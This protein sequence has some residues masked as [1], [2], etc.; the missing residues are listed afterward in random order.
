MPGSGVSPKVP[1]R[2]QR[3]EG[4][5]TTLVVPVLRR[6]RGSY[7]VE[8]TRAGSAASVRD[9]ARKLTSSAFTAFRG[10]GRKG[11]ERHH[12]ANW[13]CNRAARWRALRGRTPG[14]GRTVAPGRRRRHLPAEDYFDFSTTTRPASFMKT[15]YLFPSSH[16]AA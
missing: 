2:F 10:A 8:T 5:W 14:D 3:L 4:C 7:L 15:W 11:A 12:R 16:E 1:G 13:P 9:Q 6:K